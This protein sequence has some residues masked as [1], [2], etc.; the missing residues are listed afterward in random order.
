M[1]NQELENCEEY[2]DNKDRGYQLNMRP[3]SLFCQLK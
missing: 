2:V 1:K 3:P